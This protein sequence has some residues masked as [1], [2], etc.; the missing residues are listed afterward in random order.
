MNDSK[1]KACSSG[2]GIAMGLPLGLLIGS[3]FD[4]VALGMMFGLIFG[5]WYDAPSRA[6]PTAETDDN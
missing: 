4:N 2:T 5:V 1:D 6:C 3:M